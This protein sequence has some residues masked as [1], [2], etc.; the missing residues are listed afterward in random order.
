[1]LGFGMALAG[2]GLSATEG[3]PV[4]EGVPALTELPF[5]GYVFDAG[6]ES[7]VLI[8]LSGTADA[9]RDLEVR[10]AAP[11]VS[12]TWTAVTAD[13]NGNWSVVLE[14][15]Q[16]T[17]SHWYT[18]QARYGAGGQIAQGTASF[19]CGTVLGFLGQSE[20]TYFHA[21][22]DAYNPLSYPPLANENLTVLLQADDTGMVTPTRVAVADKDTVNMGLV[23]MA[24]ALDHAGAARKFMVLDLN[25]PGTSRGEMMD[26]S[27]TERQ[28]SH[29]ADVLALV[30]SAGSDV[31][32]VIEN[33]YNADAASI[34]NIGPIFAPWYFGQR[35]GGEA[36][37]LGSTNPDN[38]VEPARVYDHCLWDIEAAAD[39][40]GRGVFARGRTK[41]AIVGP[42]PFHDTPEAPTPE[43]ENYTGTSPRLIEPSRAVVEAF[44]T[45]SRVQTFC[46]GYGPSTHLCNFEGSIHPLPTDAY[47]TVQFALSHTPVVLN[48]IGQSVAEPTVEAVEVATDGSFADV[49]ID[50]PNGGTLTT[51]R[52]L[53]GLQ[54]PQSEP[55][56]YQDVVGFEVTR[57]G[58]QRRP[59]FKMSETGYP[60]AHR[61]T[62]VIVD[63][64][65]GT[66][67]KGKVRIT[68]QEPFG[69][70]DQIS[71]LLGQASGNLLKPRDVDAKLHLNMLIENVPALYDA[72]ADHPLRGIPVKPHAETA[73]IVLPSTF[74][75]RAAYF[76]GATNYASSSINQLAGNKG[77]MSFWFRNRDSAWNAKI[78]TRICQFRVGSQT[79]LEI[80]TTSSGRMTFQL[81]QTGS[82]DDSFTPPGN[83]FAL[84]QWHHIAWSWDQLAARFQLRVDGVM[85]D[86]SAYDWGDGDIQMAG[87]NL[88]RIGIGGNVATANQFIGDIGHFWFDLGRSVDLSDPSQ[89][90]KF[91]SN[92]VPVDLG[93]T[94]EL[95]LGTPPHYYYDGDGPSWTN[96]GTAGNVSIN[97]ALSASDTSP[98]L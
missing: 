46:V 62:A 90:S 61:G 58:G 40:S 4:P 59:V 25:Q 21:L 23:A 66:P 38:G 30:R 43:W 24:N 79:V 13:T 75:A 93:A 33:W 10:A 92:D 29:L 31:G 56:H 52:A 69:T 41:L 5:D 89:L 88:T 17:W 42:M 82:G 71:Y 37:A 16:S 76:D 9:G 28:F 27:D 77:L 34:P 19:G 70:G 84:N 67:R 18:P 73:A 85:L 54:A 65:S 26:D 20:L 8:T 72:T 47:G 74:Q 68:P 94:G 53:G 87:A 32:L 7:S 55:P 64:G 60:T 80:R 95:P 97:G 11:G 2:T 49:T 51:L 83:T 63:T 1:M 15:D 35:W 91:L 48:W 96:L 45:D 14:M 78:S 39:Q 6:Q 36:F 98:A 57:A 50:L 81:S 12:T 22:G 86:T 3:A 44:T